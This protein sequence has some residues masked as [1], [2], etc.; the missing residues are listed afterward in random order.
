MR[1]SHLLWAV[2]V[3]VVWGTSYVVIQAGLKDTTPAFFAALRAL[4]AGIGIL[5]FDRMRSERT[6]IPELSLRDGMQIFIL[7]FLCTAVF[8]WAMFEG[9]PRV[10]A[11]LASVLVNTQ[12][13]FVAGG[14]Y[15][16][17]GESLGFRRMA[18]LFSGF[19]GVVLVSVPRM[20]AGMAGDYLGVGIL[21]LG[22]GGFA[23]G[24][25]L[26]KRLYQRYDLY[27]L[28]GWQLTV[29]GLAL[30]A[31]ALGFENVTATKWTPSLIS[32]VFY[33]SLL[34]TGITSLLWFRLV[35]FHSVSTLAS[36][37]F[38]SPAVGVV[39]AWLVYGEQFSTGV[40]FGMALIMG[41]LYGM[42]GGIGG[43]KQT[44]P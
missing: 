26:S 15:A 9:T 4:P 14:A 39:M 32:S 33:L 42:G 41:G 25:V 16:F 12:P 38:L 23:A 28:T 17:L 36:F 2:P 13:F 3:M 35:R 18:S 29:G 5:L 31:M 21:L 40:V 8:F 30:M 22:A 44:P 6:R 24:L 20:S 10:G 37:G 43:R 7:G 1:F 11:G 27:W 19:S 34:G